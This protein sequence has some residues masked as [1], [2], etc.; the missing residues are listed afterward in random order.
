MS[1]P[2]EVKLDDLYQEVILDHNRRPR[3]FGKLGDANAYSH[4]YNPLCGD[5][6]H[7]YL[8]I[9]PEGK[10]EAVQFEG[11]GCAISKSSASIMTEIALGKN[12]AELEGLKESFLNMLIKEG[13]ATGLPTKL[14][15]FEGVKKFPVRV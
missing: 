14:K 11:Q 8:K 13:A 9:S 15:I 1:A 3:N 4:G 10:V 6:F 12:L 2:Q 5:D 7:I